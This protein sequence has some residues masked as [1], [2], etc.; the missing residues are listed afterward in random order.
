MSIIKYALAAGNST[1]LDILSFLEDNPNSNSN[2]IIKQTK[3]SQ[4]TVSEHLRRLSEANL[5]SVK[6]DGVNSRFAIDKNGW[7]DFIHQLNA[8]LKK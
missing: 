1:R 8:F 4:S 3:L 2:S 5:I 6:K 7:N